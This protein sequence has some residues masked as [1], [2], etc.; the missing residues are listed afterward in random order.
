MTN[1][2]HAQGTLETLGYM[3]DN[4]QQRLDAF[5]AQPH[6]ALVDI[7]YSPRSRWKPAFNQRSLIERYG[8]IKYGHCKELGNVNYNKPNVP[9]KL[10]EPY[11]GAIRVARLIRSGYACILLCA[12]KDYERCHRKVAYELIR[13]MLD[14]RIGEQVTILL[15]DLMGEQ[16]RVYDHLAGRQNEWHVRPLSW[17]EDVPGIAFRSDELLFLG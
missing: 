5:L 17:T 13:D 1:H 10:Y 12:C 16:G 11:Q 2:T 15:G 3:E 9:I 4:A 8:A 6:T 14:H 7:R